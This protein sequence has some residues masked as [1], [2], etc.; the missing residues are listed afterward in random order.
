MIIEHKVFNKI[1]L[2]Y[3]FYFMKIGIEREGLVV[4]EIRGWLDGARAFST[5]TDSSWIVTYVKQH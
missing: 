4:A 1:Y 3:E 2:S 5:E